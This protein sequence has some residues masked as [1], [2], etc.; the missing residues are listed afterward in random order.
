[1]RLWPLVDRKAHTQHGLVTLA[2]LRELGFTTAMVRT[3]RRSGQLTDV[4]PGVYRV[5]GASPS[6]RQRLLAATL[7]A[8][9]PAA[10]M[11]RSAADVWGLRADSEH[12][13]IVVPHGNSTRPKGASVHRSADLDPNHFTRRFGLPIT[14]PAR[15]I[16]DL[17]TSVSREELDEVVDR[18]LVLSLVTEAGLRVMITELSRPGRRGPPT[19]RRVLDEHPLG[20]VRPESVIEPVMAAILRDSPVADRIVYQQRV[21]VG[22]RKFR[23]DFAAPS[24]K[25]GVEVLGL[26]EHGT[27]RAVIEDSTRRRIL[28]L[29]GW[30]LLEY[31]KTYMVRSPVRVA[32]EI[33]TYVEERER[34]FPGWARIG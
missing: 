2:Q 10:V 23:M 33:S 12:V 16:L 28:R 24:V 34:Q 3:A 5:L 17:A 8:G 4:H 30:D 25:V 18:A 20:S 15:T 7:R 19:L 9:R 1:M 14:K 29:H 27:R 13:E 11:G 32:R 22:G 21:I 31:T 26:R 6:H